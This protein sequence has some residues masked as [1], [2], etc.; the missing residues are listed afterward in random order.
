MFGFRSCLP[1]RR[2]G[3]KAQRRKALPRF[4]R[5][6]CAFAPLRENFRMTQNT[7]VWIECGKLSTS[8][9][10]PSSQRKYGIFCSVRFITTAATF[11]SG[12]RKAVESS[13]L[14]LGELAMRF[15]PRSNK[16][17][18]VSDVVVGVCVDQL[19][20]ARIGMNRSEAEVLDVIRPAGFIQQNVPIGPADRAAVEVV[21]HRTPVQLA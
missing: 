21:D 19:A 13:G 2:K 11:P 4:K 16:L 1:Q 12:L 20:G 10:C 7:S 14:R 18:K 17:R 5:F 6:L 3:A 15:A 9:A 8:A